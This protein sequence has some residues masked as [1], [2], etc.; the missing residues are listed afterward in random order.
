MAVVQGGAALAVAAAFGIVS[1]R[2]SAAAVLVGGIAIALGNVV[3]AHRL[4]A[5]GVKAPGAILRG[6]YTAELLKWLWLVVVLSL[7]IAVFKLPF[8]PLLAGMAT[9][10]LAFWIG[11]LLYRE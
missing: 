1:G 5:G 7:A 10:M 8:L 6:F 2:P 3:F 9:A 11:L 4:F